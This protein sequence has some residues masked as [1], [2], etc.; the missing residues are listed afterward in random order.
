[1]KGLFGRWLKFNFV[2]GLGIGVQLVALW[3]L[4]KMFG[5]HYLVAT[6]LAVETAVVHNFVWHER[7][8]WKKRG[9]GSRWA[10]VVRFLRFQVANGLISLIGNLALMRLLVGVFGVN[11][12]IANGAAIAVCSLANFAAGEWFVF[13]E[14]QR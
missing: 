7:F 8:T 6:A 5:L 9:G 3:I 10:V 4:L 12:L 14:T 11:H 13:R 1:M 2:G